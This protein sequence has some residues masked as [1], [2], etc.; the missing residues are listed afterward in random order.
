MPKSAFLCIFLEK[1]ALFLYTIQSIKGVIFLEQKPLVSIIMSE[2]STPKELLIDSIK[3]MLD[4]IYK[5]FEF[6]IVDDKGKNNLKE[7]TDTFKD[8]RIK[9]LENEKNMGLVKSLNRAI[10]V[11]QGKYLARMDTDDFSYPERLEK[12]VEF[13]E[14]HPE[15]ALVSGRATYFDGE[16]ITAE[17]NWSGEV[18]KKELKKGPVSIIHPSVMMRTEAAKKVGGYQDFKRCEDYAMWINLALNDYRMFVMDDVLIRYHLSLTDYSKRNL[19]S[20]EGLFRLIKTEYKKLKPSFFEYSKLYL[21][22]FIA[23]IMPHKLMAWYHKR[24]F[25]G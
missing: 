20:R 7:I 14:S 16:R 6:I 18:T 4:Q 3:S 10:E 13:L 11:A 19:K 25:R 23:G 12:Q 21:K 22:T 1:K 17:T 2:Y 8:E 9:V 15:F 5:N 24:K